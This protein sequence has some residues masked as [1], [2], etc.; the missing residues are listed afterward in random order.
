MKTIKRKRT[1][2]KYGY[3]ISLIL[4]LI[5]LIIPIIYQINV[6]MPLIEIASMWGLMILFSCI[7][8]CFGVFTFWSSEYIDTISYT[9][10]S[11]QVWD[12]KLNSY[13]TKYTYAGDDLM[14]DFIGPYHLKDWIDSSNRVF[15]QMK[16][17][18]LTYDLFT[19]KD[20]AMKHL[21]SII[22][23]MKA[24]KLAEQRILIKDGK[25]EITYSIEELENL[26]ESKTI[27]INENI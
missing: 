11:F 6:S 22:R 17:P 21:L 18:D 8:G 19:S 26:L 5:F 2:N 4:G 20:S 25:A 13:M 10:Y 3:I 9:I 12:E 1:E 7:T 14:A 16:N 27:N 23:S 15:D 24:N